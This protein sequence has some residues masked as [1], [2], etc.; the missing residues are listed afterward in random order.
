MRN[1]NTLELG[2]AAAL[3]S[4]MCALNG[5]KKVVITDYPDEQIIN[6]ILKN[7]KT[8]DLLNDDTVKVQGY[9]WGDDVQPLLKNLE[10]DSLFDV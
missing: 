8:N 6:S 7:T 4:F 10:S 3:P 1:F 5:A 9:L 2:A